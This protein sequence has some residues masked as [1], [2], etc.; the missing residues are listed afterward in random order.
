[1]NDDQG[2]RPLRARAGK[3]LTGRI[4]V[5]GDKSISHR[6][7]MLGALAIGR[8]SVAGMLE[9]EDVLNTA[10]AMRALGARVER[11][12][13]GE[14]S[15]DGL[16]VGGLAQP[17]DILDFG[18]AGTGARLALG[19]LAGNPLT[20]TLT[21]DASL[22]KRPMG[23]VTAPLELMGARFVAREGN[24]LPLT[25]TGTDAPLPIE[26]RLPVPSAQV[27]SAILLAGLSS[28]GTTILIEP[29]PT[30]DHTERMLRHFGA[31]LSVE[32]T[33]DG[34]VVALR[35]QPELQAA[36]I[37][38]PGDPSSAAFPIVA[39]LIVPGSDITIS[40]V[41]FNPLRTGLI[42]T[43]R[44]MGASI[45][46]VNARDEGGEPV[47][48]LRVRASELKGV[49]VPAERAPSM[50]DEYPIL[51]MAA[52]CA[53]GT[54]DMAGLAELRVKESDRLAAVANGLAACGAT[55]E[56]GSDR[57]IVTGN[58]KPPAGGATIPTGLDH[59][60]AMSFLVLGLVA[61]QTIAVDDARPIDTSFPDFAGRMA[62]LGADIGSA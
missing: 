3:A 52:A 30:R 13:D 44:E 10:S 33:K 26:Y 23:R 27:K 9:G 51:A 8:T 57:L 12:G 48:D 5:P 43:L 14:W 31:S 19:L 53:E 46:I 11:T 37:R 15:V 55:V 60:I 45:D 18:N 56:A 21:G 4:G 62:A 32:D 50:I 54:T 35:G 29:E 6:A 22:R 7:L 41:G 2:P 20:A 59:R 58:G 39:A 34:R 16:G 28:P 40:H 38:V 61:R 24:L 47:G 36:T 17:D 49:R 25:I 42:D 1:M